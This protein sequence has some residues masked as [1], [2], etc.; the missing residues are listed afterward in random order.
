MRLELNASVYANGV[1]VKHEISRAMEI[2]DDAHNT[3]T[4]RDAQFTSIVDGKHSA[5][6]LHYVG[7]AVDLRTWYIPK[8]ELEDFAVQLRTDLGPDYDV[9][10]EKT[11]IHIEFQPTR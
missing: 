9:V 2:V 3:W 11:H 5:K 8:K 6:S 4:G 7:L 1:A 10:V